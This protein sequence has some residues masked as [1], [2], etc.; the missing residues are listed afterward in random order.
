MSA[1]LPQAYGQ[2]PVNT[3]PALDSAATPAMPR[4][5]ERAI[6]WGGVGLMSAAAVGAVLLNLAYGEAA[7]AARLIAGIAGCL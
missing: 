7:F 3:S 2:Q 1:P 6:V 4:A 5:V